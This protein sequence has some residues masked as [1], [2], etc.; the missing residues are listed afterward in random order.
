MKKEKIGFLLHRKKIFLEVWNCNFFERFRGL[1]FRKKQNAKAL[2]FKFKKSSN[3]SIHSFFVFFEFYGI[4]L[5]D[6]NKILK[7]EKINPFR[8]QIF[9]PKKFSKLIEIPVNGRYSEIVQFLDGDSKDL[10]R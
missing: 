9:S 1:M 10:N 8:F 3:I 7:I 4:W 6:K 5:D 2:L